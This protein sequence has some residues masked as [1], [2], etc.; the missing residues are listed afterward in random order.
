MVF[1]HWLVVVVVVAKVTIRFKRSSST[2]SCDFI[3]LLL[4]VYH[5]TFHVF[6]NAVVSGNFTVVQVYTCAPAFLP[7][8]LPKQRSKLSIEGTRFTGTHSCPV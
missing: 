8:L 2:V 3:C 1:C 6:K 4:H 5:A 7:T